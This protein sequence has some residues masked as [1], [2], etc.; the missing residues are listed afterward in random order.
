ME[1]H[2]TVFIS[3][4]YSMSSDYIFLQTKP[5]KGLQELMKMKAALLMILVVAVSFNLCAC[6]IPG[7]MEEEHGMYKD[8]RA[9]KD[10]RKL[11]DIDGRTAP[12]GHDYDHVCPRV[13]SCIPPFANL[14]ITAKTI[15]NIR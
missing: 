11:I 15:F 6:N 14:C 13:F 8:V 12:I 1:I 4:K 9:G 7:N 10:M 3:Y 5:G 2:S